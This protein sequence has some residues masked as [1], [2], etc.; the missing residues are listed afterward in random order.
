MR[1]VSLS[2]SAEPLVKKDFRI[3][4]RHFT[5]CSKKILTNTEMTS[6]FRRASPA[7]TTYELSTDFLG[8]ELPPNI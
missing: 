1:C 8:S 4:L 6:I 7:G 2:A 3:L 5:Y